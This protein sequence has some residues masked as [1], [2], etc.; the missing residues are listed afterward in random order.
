MRD[1]VGASATATK[2]TTNAV[3]VVVVV[4][5]VVV[6]FLVT[7]PPMQHNFNPIV[8]SAMC[9]IV[10][11]VVGLMLMI[12]VLMLSDEFSLLRFHRQ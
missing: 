6:L 4:V 2:T 11:R 5:V 9:T 7:T 3:A 10:A 1:I 12:L 8:N